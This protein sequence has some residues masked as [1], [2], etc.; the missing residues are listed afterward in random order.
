M[1]QQPENISAKT[2]EEVMKSPEWKN[3][4]SSV[5]LPLAL[6]STL[7]SGLRAINTQ[8]NLCAIS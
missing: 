4:L 2:V 5:Y 1:K 7:T 8:M 6:A 3:E